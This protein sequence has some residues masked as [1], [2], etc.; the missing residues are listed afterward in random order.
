MGLS[1]NE[2][3]A[4]LLIHASFI[5]YEFHPN[6]K[7][8]IIKAYGIKTFDK[9]MMKYLTDR[10]NSFEYLRD[11]LDVYFADDVAKLNLKDELFGLLL[12]DYNYNQLEKAF[13]DLFRSEMMVTSHNS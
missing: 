8:Y 12:A 5:D 4:L 1:V 10:E 9:M 13:M 11:N 7:Q 3:K 2:F 6:E